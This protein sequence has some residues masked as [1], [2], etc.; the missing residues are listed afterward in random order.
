M[1]YEEMTQLPNYE[2]LDDRMKKVVESIEKDGMSL[3]EVGRQ[4]NLTR[5][6]ARQLYAKAMRTLKTPL[7]DLTSQNRKTIIVYPNGDIAVIDCYTGESIF[8]KPYCKGD[9]LFDSVKAAFQSYRNSTF[10]DQPIEVFG[11]PLRVMNCLRRHSERTGKRLELVRDL[12]GM[13]EEQMKMVRNLGHKSLQEIKE[14]LKEHGLRF[15][16]WRDSL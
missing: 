13:T 8:R 15:R 16:D 5:E 1:T 14:K 12:V 11:F 4:L 9:D 7:V 10:L 2:S 3:E 6:R